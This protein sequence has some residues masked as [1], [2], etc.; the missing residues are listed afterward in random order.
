MSAMRM[1]SRSLWVTLF[2]AVACLLPSMASA[3]DQAFRDGMEARDDKKWQ[4]VVTLMR[5]AIAANPQESPRRVEFGGKLGFGRKWTQYLPQFYLGEALFRMDDCPGAVDAWGTSEK[6]GVV[7][8]NAELLKFLQNGYVTCEGKGVL[9][10]ARFDPLSQQASEQF[11]EASTLA[12]TIA[13]IGQ[14]SQDQWTAPLRAQYDGA[15]R[16]LENARAKI[17][18]A[19][20]TRA[21]RDLNDAAATAQKARG[22]MVALSSALDELR[23][24][25]TV[26]GDVEQMLV[27]LDGTDRQIE[28]RLTTSKAA[29]SPA[30][31]GVRQQGRE[32]IS[33]ARERLSEGLKGNLAAFTEARALGVEAS[34]KYRQLLDEVARVEREARGTQLQDAIAGGEEGLLLLDRLVGVLSARLAAK[35]ALADATVTGERAAITSDAAAVRRRFEAA[36][37]AG[38]MAALQQAR[39]QTQRTSD[40]INALLA[41]FGPLT[42]RER[43]VSEALEEGARQFFAGAYDKALAALDAPN[44]VAADVPLQVHVHLFRAA[45]LYG[46]YVRSSNANDALRARAVK[47]VAEC[48]K[49]DSSFEPDPRAFSPK[50]IG[51][52]KGAQTATTTTTAAAAAP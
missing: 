47:E 43:G 16:E 10:P 34:A 45:A 18:T 48:R 46:L 6:H 50:F 24:A 36:R 37:A 31:I 3:Q 4:Q 8:G 30:M 51:F 40:R 35:P 42:L 22:M 49:L 44:A 38:N 9:P 11:A 13:A 28:A 39:Q 33:R 5:R 7:R 32:A 15:S 26:Q 29:L 52:F 21:A 17:A 25:Q 12:A 1:A 19:T 41:R 23:S 27:A 20:R 14:Q 2:A